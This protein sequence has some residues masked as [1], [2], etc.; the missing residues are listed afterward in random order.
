MKD[1]NTIRDLQLIK[2]KWNLEEI[3]PYA[4][5]T[6]VITGFFL[7]TILSISLL[8]P[9]ND[10]NNNNNNNDNYHHHQSHYYPYNY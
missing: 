10:N 7:F 3:G 5:T 9:Y 6:T 8:S 1:P 2:E 4:P